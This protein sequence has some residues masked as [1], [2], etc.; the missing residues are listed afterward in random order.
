M[1]YGKK[2]RGQ[3]GKGVEMRQGPKVVVIDEATITIQQL[4]EKMDVRGTCGRWI[5]ASPI[6]RCGESRS[7]DHD[8]CLSHSSSST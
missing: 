1:R 8:P 7:S 2:R 5:Q 6:K 4:S 3:K